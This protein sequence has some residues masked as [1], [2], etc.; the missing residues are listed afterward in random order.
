VFVQTAVVKKADLEVDPLRAKAVTMVQKEAEK[1]K[2]VD[3]SLL[4]MRM[5]AD[6]FAKIK[7]LIQELIERLLKEAAQEANQKGWCDTSLAKANTDR[8]FRQGD[9]DDL[10]AEINEMAASK[11]TLEENVKQLKREVKEAEKAHA[12]AARIR[13]REKRENKRELDNA[14]EGLSA[15]QDA[16]GVLKDFYKGAAKASVS[17]VQTDGSPVSQKMASQGTGEHLGA[18]QGEQEQAA[19]ILGMLATIES[20]FERTIKQTSAS[21]GAAA[22]AF[23]KFDRETKASVAGKSTAIARAEAD[24]IETTGDLKATY[25]SLQQNQLLLDTA[26]KTLETLRPQCVDTTMSHDERL[27]RREAEVAALKTA[28]CTLDEQDGEISECAQWAGFLQKK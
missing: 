6:P 25:F 5:A 18:Y 15:L 2:S 27:A 21:E 20:D 19:G 26:M 14:S 17:F 9:L 13:S 4:A 11:V 10:S 23:T 22:A 7:T 24:I 28:V 3:L 16:I 8:D 1:L 12:T